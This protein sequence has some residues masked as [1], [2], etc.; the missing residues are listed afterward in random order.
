MILPLIMLGAVADA[1]IAPSS[2]RKVPSRGATEAPGLDDADLSALSTAATRMQLERRF[3]RSVTRR[4]RVYLPYADAARWARGLGLSTEAEW[5]EWVGLG[6]GKNAYVP[7][8]PA[9]YYGGRGEWVSWAHYLVGGAD[10]D[11]A[12][13]PP[14]EVLPQNYFADLDYAGDAVPWDLRGRPQPAVRKAWAAGAFR[15]CREILD[16]G[17]GAGDNANYLASR[18]HAVTGFDLSPSAVAAARERAAAP[19]FAD[20]IADAGGSARF[21]VA[22]C[23][24]LFDSPVYALAEEIGGF[25]VAL[26]SALLHCFDL[27]RIFTSSSRCTYGDCIGSMAWGPKFDF[28]TGLDDKMQRR[29]VAEL[30]RVVRTGGRLYVGCFSDANPDPWS[31]PRR[32]SEAH[33]RALFAGPAWRVEAVEPAWYERPRALN[34]GHRSGAWTMAWWCRICRLG[35]M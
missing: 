8:R 19:P 29:Y 2:I 33:L 16:C 30:A 32:L 18:G 1:F 14:P 7:S 27:C 22:S 24:D 25:P 17:C 9:D 26:D 5:N 4:K 35:A 31:N 12:P 20:S 28:H 13:A 6:E 15:N 10:A 34:E 23:A 3:S 21:E 11:A